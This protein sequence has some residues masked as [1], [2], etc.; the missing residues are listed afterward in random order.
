MIAS[1]TQNGDNFA[2]TAP[3]RAIRLVGGF[4]E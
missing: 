4:E 2:S 1:I 3:V